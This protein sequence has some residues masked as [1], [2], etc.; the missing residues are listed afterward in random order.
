MSNVY[1]CF[2][3]F[4]NKFFPIYSLIFLLALPVFVHLIIYLIF[5]IFKKN[6]IPNIQVHPVGYIDPI[7]INSKLLMKSILI[8]TLLFDI[9]GYGPKGILSTIDLRLNQSIGIYSALEILS[10]ICLLIN[11]GLFY[12]INKEI[13]KKIT[14][15]C[16]C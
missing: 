15:I 11:I 4:P 2:G 7:E 14:S 1:I 16:A 6:E 13:R 12:K 3:Y 5:I 10:S 9:I 8:M